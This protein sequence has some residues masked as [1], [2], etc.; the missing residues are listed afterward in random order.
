MSDP[1]AAGPES[2][3]RS[4]RIPAVVLTLDRGNST[5]DARCAGCDPPRQRFVPDAELAGRLER[6]LGAV[7][8]DVAVGVTVVPDGL[9][10]V[11]PVLDARGVALV[12]A[13][14]DLPC[15]LTIAY[16]DPSTLGRDRWLGALAAVRRHGDAVVLDCGTALTVNAV[17]V[18][19]RFLGGSI[20][21]GLRSTGDALAMR[22]PALPRFD[23]HVPAAMPAGSS[24]DAVRAGVGFGVVAGALALVERAVAAFGSA[25]VTRVVTGGDA[26]WFLSICA[27][28]DPDAAHAFV[29]EP[30]LV[31]DGLVALWRGSQPNS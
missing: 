19:D 7:R 27:A 12:L 2:R 5:L 15:P 22:A 10:V 11:R 6:W 4:D 20:G 13:G 16:D 28:L 18:G 21:L 29:A 1:S 30:E 25:S 26:A 3:A 14:V 31:H 17:A 24:L 9:A 8:P 23:G